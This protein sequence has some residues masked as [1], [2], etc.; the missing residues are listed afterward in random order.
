MAGGVN[1]VRCHDKIVR[2]CLETLRLRL[3]FEIQLAILHKIIVGE[4]L[5]GAAGEQRRDIGEMVLQRRNAAEF[6]QQPRG[7]AA[8]SAA[9]FKNT[10]WLAGLTRLDN[11]A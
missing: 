7:G 5:L 9:N 1:H 3:F 11:A 2:L 4:F 10:Q 6:R 8:G